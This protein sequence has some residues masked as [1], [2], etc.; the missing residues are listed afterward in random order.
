[1]VGLKVKDSQ[2]ART[3]PYAKYTAYER[4]IR[5]AAADWFAGRGIETHPRRPYSVRDRRDWPKNIISPEVVEYIKNE[6]ARHLGETPYPLHPYLHH[7]LS[8]QA[9]TFNLIGPLIVRSDFEP[10]REVLESVGVTWPKGT[11]TVEFE[12]DDRTVFNEQSRQPTSFDV[13]VKGEDAAIYI[14]AKL[15]EREFGGCSV[16]S[17]GDCDG[18]NPL[19]HGL[20]GCYLH[21][22]GRTYWKRMREFQFDKTAISSGQICPFTIYYQ[23]FREVLFSLTKGGSFILLH[24]ERNPAFLR[25]SK[26]GKKS[27]LWPFLTGSIPSQY[28]SRI[29]RI[30]IQQLTEAIERTRRHQDWIDEFKEK[31]GIQ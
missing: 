24:D 18:R 10:L 6:A 29:A 3:W 14:E 7:G 16:F 19:L 4:E 15:V 12:H 1:M 28:A 9:M 26:N 21:H 2:L 11:I 20:D 25:L 17:R 13:L 31:Y 27:G 5:S 8:S 23:F 30:T 22:I